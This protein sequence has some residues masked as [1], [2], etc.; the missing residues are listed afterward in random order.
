MIVCFDYEFM[1]FFFLK[2]DELDNLFGN[3]NRLVF[4]NELDLKYFSEL[5]WFLEV[6]EVFKRETEC[7]YN[8]KS[9]IQ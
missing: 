7:N 8:Q 3:I 1:N 6:I 2:N 9:V 5:H 4:H